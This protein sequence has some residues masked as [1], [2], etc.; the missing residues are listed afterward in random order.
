ME[1]KENVVIGAFNKL[2][3][4]VNEL[5]FNSG[6]VQSIYS[7][8]A[9]NKFEEVIDRNENAPL[10][11][12]TKDIYN[13]SG[14][15]IKSNVRGN[16]SVPSIQ[17]KKAIAD[18]NLVGY[19]L[20]ENNELASKIKANDDSYI[21]NGSLGSYF[22]PSN[23]GITTF[24]KLMVDTKWAGCA[25]LF[26]TER[27]DLKI[28]IRFPNRDN[29]AYYITNFLSVSFSEEVT[30]V[31]INIA[32][33]LSGLNF[34]KVKK[35]L[36]EGLEFKDTINIGEGLITAK[37]TGKTILAVA[38]SD[39][40]DA[41]NKNFISDTNFN[42]SL[43]K[44]FKKWGN[45]LIDIRRP[46]KRTVDIFRIVKVFASSQF[47]KTEIT[48]ETCT[49][50]CDFSLPVEN[51]A[52]NYLKLG[53]D[54][55]LQDYGMKSFGI[56]LNK[57]MMKYLIFAKVVDISKGFQS[58]YTDKMPQDKKKA[59]KELSKRFRSVSY[60]LRKRRML[61][62]LKRS[63]DEMIKNFKMEKLLAFIE[64]VGEYNSEK[65]T[66]KVFDRVNKKF[67]KI[68]VIS[69]DFS[70][71]SSF[72][73]AELF[74]GPCPNLNDDINFDNPKTIISTLINFVEKT[75][76]PNDTSI[77]ETTNSI[78]KQKI[79][80]EI[81][82]LVKNEHNDNLYNLTIKMASYNDDNI[83]RTR[84]YISIIETMDLDASLIAACDAILEF[85]NRLMFSEKL[86]KSQSQETIKD[87]R[88]V[89]KSYQL[90]DFVNIA[91]KK[92]ESFHVRKA[93]PLDSE[94]KEVV[95]SN[96]YVKYVMEEL[97][98]KTEMWEEEHKTYLDVDKQISL[99]AAYSC[100][101]L[102]KMIDC[103]LGALNIDYDSTIPE[104]KEYVK[105]IVS[106]GIQANTDIRDILA[107]I[108]PVFGL[109]VATVNL[110][111]T[112]FAGKSYTN[113]LAKYSFANILEM[114]NTQAFA[115]DLKLFFSGNGV[116]DQI[117]TRDTETVKEILRENADSAEILYGDEIYIKGTNYAELDSIAN[118]VKYKKNKKTK[119]LVKKNREIV[120]KKNEIIQSVKNVSVELSGKL[121]KKKIGYETEK[122]INNE[123][124][125]NTNLEMVERTI[126]KVKEKKSK[127]MKNKQNEV[128]QILQQMPQ[129]LEELEGFYNEFIYY[130]NLGI[131]AINADPYVNMID[132]DWNYLAD[133][134]QAIKDGLVD[135]NKEDILRVDSLSPKMVNIFVKEIEKFRQLEE[136]HKINLRQNP[137]SMVDIKSNARARANI[138][139]EK[140]RAKGGVSTR[141]KQQ[142]VNS[143]LNVQIPNNIPNS[144]IVPQNPNI[145][146]SS[147]DIDDDLD[148]QI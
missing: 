114:M 1:K 85:I 46:D 18:M 147:M 123:A 5:P 106:Y 21:K 39:Y 37:C 15:F 26:E 108:F 32:N 140:S 6:T 115:N 110:V 19:V 122:K 117:I 129:M 131:Q 105:T 86:S 33:N 96:S 22:S 14:S 138:I 103:V 48:D 92:L 126:D 63:A 77:Y 41:S 38:K 100:V 4:Q 7:K 75:I 42:N 99:A 144:N 148:A 112:F 65:P 146:S 35:D 133:T 81:D 90:K 29:F 13:G 101:G 109:N 44:K 116:I 9:R 30:E 49:V 52:T 107:L 125:D 94:K 64:K 16:F 127:R 47:V 98:K 10:E 95:T 78:V 104:Y 67:V 87:L 51:L 135:I 31:N 43:L 76:I 58:L 124:E 56:F 128:Q 139:N 141:S 3:Y 120:V 69:E 84:E 68:D 71:I 25:S 34:S 118:E 61:I 91:V 12:F 72:L 145:Q 143:N 136:D 111:K 62:Q 83:K 59:D 130:K 23:E 11:A 121:S 55:F 60:I 89:F 80:T 2:R 66:K 113:E 137:Q 20:P 57:N 8:I 27:K 40:W 93:K 88:L 132:S 54:T 36:F 97:E 119:K 50:S 79:L 74:L 134:T 82:T 53:S 73:S 45:S 28:D 17:I 102:I 70:Y 142:I 24:Y